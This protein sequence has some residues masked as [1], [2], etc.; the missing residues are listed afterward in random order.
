MASPLCA[1]FQNYI[2]LVQ[3]ILNLTTNWRKNLHPNHVLCRSQPSTL[4]EGAFCC[5]KLQHGSTFAILFLY[6]LRPFSLSMSFF[7]GGRILVFPLWQRMYIAALTIINMG[8]SS[9]V[10]GTHKIHNENATIT[11]G[12]LL[13]RILV[14]CGKILDFQTS[15]RAIECFKYQLK[16]LPLQQL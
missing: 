5:C 11:V 10:P 7:T 4:G 16:I 1:V 2:I 12:V 13:R 15:L 14:S 6:A 3:H 8:D 9:P